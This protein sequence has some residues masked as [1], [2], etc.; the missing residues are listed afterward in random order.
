MNTTSPKS[1]II[2][3]KYATA[4]IKKARPVC[5]EKIEKGLEYDVANIV[6]HFGKHFFTRS[7]CSKQIASMFADK[8]GLGYI[9][10]NWGNWNEILRLGKIVLDFGIE[11]EDAEIIGECGLN[12]ICFVFRERCE[13]NEVESRIG[14]A[15]EVNTKL[16]S[17]WLE[18]IIEKTRADLYRR[19]GY[20]QAA[21]Q[22]YI[23]AYD[24]FTSLKKV[25][26]IAD[27][28]ISLGGIT[29]E[30]AINNFKKAIDKSGKTKNSLKKA[31]EYF[32][33]A[34]HYLDN[35]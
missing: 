16:K 29:L 27:I 17:R 5:Y 23:K 10:K 11:Q 34:T 31:E 19:R 20:F 32:E 12:Q 26:D 9:L 33:R 28:C 18:A 13:F 7:A 6:A 3:N 25:D 22:S 21:E 2:R 30:I 24:I 14:L 35:G 4:I 8:R 1:V 15:I